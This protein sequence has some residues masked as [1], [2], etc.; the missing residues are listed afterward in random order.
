MVALSCFLLLFSVLFLIFPNIPFSFFLTVGE[1]LGD[2][3]IKLFPSSL[4][5]LAVNFTVCLQISQGMGMRP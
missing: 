5:Q 2:I 1:D 3:F 4:S